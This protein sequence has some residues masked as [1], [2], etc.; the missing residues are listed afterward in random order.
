MFSYKKK[1]FGGVLALSILSISTVN[2]N[3]LVCPE[4]KFRHIKSLKDSNSTFT[5]KNNPGKFSFLK[6]FENLPSRIQNPIFV[7]KGGF[8]PTLVGQENPGSAYLVCHYKYRTL[9]GKEYEFSI[10]NNPPEDFLLNVMSIDPSL[11]NAST[12]FETINKAYKKAALKNHPDKPT[13]SEEKM[14]EINDS[15]RFIKDVFGVK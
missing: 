12:T 4:L 6:G 10:M 9:I 1:C 8:R 15:M 5:V 11:N 14:K 2:A 3:K 7:S 13:G